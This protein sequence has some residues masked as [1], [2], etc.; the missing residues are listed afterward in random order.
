MRDKTT[1]VL[2]MSRKKDF[3]QVLAVVPLWLFHKIGIVSDEVIDDFF[4]PHPG[5]GEFRDWD[6]R[7]Q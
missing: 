6:R 5:D 1:G 7:D 3:L 2:E 4:N